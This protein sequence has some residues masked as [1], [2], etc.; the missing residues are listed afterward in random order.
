[1]S[2]IKLLI[3]SVLTSFALP[4]IVALIVPMLIAYLDPFR[5]GRWAP[6][7][8][9]I[10]VG[11]FILI[12]CIR[13]FYALGK[14]TLAPWNPP[15]ELVVGGFY[16]FVRNP[17]YSGVLLLVSGLG[18][19]YRSPALLLY[20]I[21]LALLFHLRVV[22][23]EEPRLKARF[24][25]QWDSYRNGVRRWLPRIKPWSIDEQD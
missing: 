22:I 8:P 15:K 24:G 17:M 10:C 21:I 2:N 18:I 1:M 20:V 13:D 23:S 9:V 7:I 12:W 11:A 25:T 19:F 4:G 16:R 14:G 5:A 6:G 3:S